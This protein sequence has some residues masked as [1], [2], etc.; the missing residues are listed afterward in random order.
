MDRATSE[1]QWGGDG[2]GPR[3]VAVE[4]AVPPHQYRQEDITTA[5]ADLLPGPADAHR[6][7]GRVSANAGV[8]TRNLSLPLHQYAALDGF[9]CAN[10]AWLHT[11]LELGEQV[12]NVALSA[13]GVEPDEVDVVISTTVTGLAVPSLEA[14]LAQR[15]GLRQDVK[16]IPLF[17][18]GCAAGAAGIARLHDYLRAFPD[19][20]GVL[21]GVELCSLTVQRGDW[22]LAN[23][24][25]TSLFGDG[26]AAVVAVGEQR[27][28][29][30]RGPEVV[31]TRSRLYPDST[32]V[33]GWRIGANGFGIVLSPDV[34][35]VAER[36]LPKDV[37]AFLAD[38]GLTVGDVAAWICHPGGPKVIDAV[39]RALGLPE[40]A[41]AH[42]RHS[43]ATRGNLSSVSVLDVLRATLEAPPAPGCV[44]LLTAMGPGFASELVLLRW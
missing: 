26:A 22:S 37:S 14:R 19:Q 24:V 25:A 7:L 10:R 31:A 41:L 13:A 8:V 6:A 34:P 2:A 30:C 15:I 36:E 40:Q 29:G 28:R 9:T 23:L 43:L 12:V 39:E 17:G 11:A 44:G 3:V 21:L 33:M 35:T 4:V 5:F 38:H 32:D 16:R 1:P 42:T 20:V 27:A 18:L